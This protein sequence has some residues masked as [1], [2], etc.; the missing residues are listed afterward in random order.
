MVMCRPGLH[1]SESVELAGTKYGAQIGTPR[2]AQLV[3][4]QSREL[5]SSP[6][7]LTVSG[8]APIQGGAPFHIV[9]N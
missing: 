9:K 6:A 3:N 7:F 4:C 8:G 1:N 5:F 2:S